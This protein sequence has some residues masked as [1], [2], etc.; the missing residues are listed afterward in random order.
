MCSRRRSQSLSKAFAGNL[1]R[2]ITTSFRLLTR[3]VNFALFILLKATSSLSY[4][5]QSSNGRFVSGIMWWPRGSPTFC[6]Q[7]YVQLCTVSLSCHLASEAGRYFCHIQRLVVTR[8]VLALTYDYS[9]SKT[10]STRPLQNA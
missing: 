10:S 6:H 7:P 4:C 2:Y 8:K 5:Y 3:L 9:V 1:Q